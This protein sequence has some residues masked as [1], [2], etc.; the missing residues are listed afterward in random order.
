MREPQEQAHRTSAHQATERE[1]GLLPRRSDE[2]QRVR[3][4]GLRPGRAGLR[5]SNC[6]HDQLRRRGPDSRWC[7][8]LKR[9]RDPRRKTDP[10]T[11]RGDSQADR[12]SDAPRPVRPDSLSS[13]LPPL[14][15]PAGRSNTRPMGHGLGP[16]PSRVQFMPHRPKRRNLPIHLPDSI[17][18]GPRGVQALPTVSI[19]RGPRPSREGGRREDL[20]REPRETVRPA[21]T[22]RAT[23][24]E[25]GLLHRRPTEPQRVRTLEHRSRCSNE[26]RRPLGVKN[27]WPPSRPSG[28]PR[29]EPPPRTS[30]KAR[31]GSAFVLYR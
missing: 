27:R 18:R 13:P 24:R 8:T 31:A 16:H 20:V 6:D 11:A 26:R 14:L 19:P 23:E 25:Q 7:L 28:P 12:V 21:T 9:V 3:T 4:D 2:P 10:S 29:A 17:P 15:A 22:I 1:Q 30:A 5:A